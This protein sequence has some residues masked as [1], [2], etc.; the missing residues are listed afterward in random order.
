MKA[1][2]VYA[3]IRV[4]NLEESLK[5]YTKVLGMKVSGR[6]T[7]DPVGG[8]F[9]NLVSEKSGFELE[10]NYYRPGSRFDVPYV[11]GEGVD[12][13][14]FDVP[15]LDKALA[16]A[17][18]LGYPVVEEMHRPETGGRWVYLRDPNGIDIKLSE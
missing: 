12:H 2:F 8:T 7:F 5:F 13:L 6:G 4:K 17:A 9:V 15:D 3:G 1:R 11:V 16:D 10:L 18:R 14:A